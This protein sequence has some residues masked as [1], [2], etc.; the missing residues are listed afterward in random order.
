MSDSMKK[1]TFLHG[2]ALLALATAMVKVI[3]A[4]YKL[5]LN[6]II[7][8]QGFGY[9]NTAYQ[10][11]N[12]LLMVSTAGLP[13]AMSR[14]ISQAS[15]VGDYGRMRRIY[16]VSRTIFLTLG[17]I[18]AGL[19]F[20][21][22]GVLA[23]ALGQPNAQPAIATLAPASFLICLMSTYRGFFQGQRNMI[24]TSVSQVLEAFVKLIVGIA[25]AL[26]IKFYTDSIPLAA[27]GAIFGVTM[28]C[29]VSSFYLNRCYR[30]AM[31]DMPVVES[32]GSKKEIA[33]GLL[34]I[35]VPIT[36]G[37]AGL[38]LLT[39]LETGIYM[40]RLFNNVDTT[41][42]AEALLQQLAIYG[43]DMTEVLTREE[44]IQFVI[45]TQKG[46]YDMAI[47]I[48]NMPCAFITPITVSVIPAITAQISTDDAEGAKRTEESAARVTALIA[49]PCAVGLAVL[50][51]PVTAL[52]GGY[53]GEMLALAAQ[54][55]T[56]LGVCIMFN[57]TVLLTNAIMQAHGRVN[58]PVI[59]MFVGGFIKLA[60]IFI[61]TGNPHIGI[62]GTPI[63]SL[64]CYL[65]ITVLNI[66]TVRRVL[67]NPPAIVRNMAR[68]F[69]AAAIMGVITYGAWFGLK[70]IGITSRV[71]LCGAPI[72]VGGV[73]YLV[74]AIMLKAITRADCELL[75]K[76]DKIAKLL[77]L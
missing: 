27:G 5:P 51:E 15:S 35:A 17:V 16:T 74:A 24:P 33:K 25:A 53:S 39:T 22:S 32:T 57:A 43:H 72:A 47:T 14:M 61:L 36:I 63:G 26:L 6:Q 41:M 66:I 54:L 69:L 46:I 9:F 75:P 11:Y 59:N 48:F 68:G 20:G 50:A 13:V 49:M 37:S 67:P 34:A 23:N 8:V 44:S 31:K 55:M 65:T 38:Q 40:D 19:M 4:L 52:L 3:G 76:G 42:N 21:F 56:V 30:K 7:G 10:I 2:T 28:S 18:S 62:L 64:L 1:Q 45:D 77:H 71:I 58:L 73:V 70:L 60:A 29:L 12:V